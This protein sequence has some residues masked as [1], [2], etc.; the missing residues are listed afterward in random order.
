MNAQARTIVIDDPPETALTLPSLG[1][2]V[3]RAGGRTA[4]REVAWRARR[5]LAANSRA[6]AN[7]TLAACIHPRPTRSAIEN[8]PR[9]DRRKL[10]LAA[11]RLRGEERRWRRLYGSS[12]S[13]D[14]R[15][16]AVMLWSWERDQARLVERLRERRAELDRAAAR[17]AQEPLPSSAPVRLPPTLLGGG[18]A[19]HLSAL[20][21]PPRTVDR[22]FRSP[23]YQRMTGASTAMAAVEGIQKQLPPFDNL[24]TALGTSTLVR[25][26]NRGAPPG[27]ASVL[28][29]YT[30]RP[31]SPLDPSQT[32]QASIARSLEA[33]IAPSWR[34]AI[35]PSLSDQLAKVVP[36][37]EAVKVLQ[38]TLAGALGASAA[39]SIKANLAP[40]FEPSALRTALDASR[41]ATQLTTVLNRP[42]FDG[43]TRLL[44]QPG[45]LA[46]LVPSIRAPLDALTQLRD[47]LAPMRGLQESFA[48]VA[49]FMRSW[50]DDPLWFL[51]SVFGMGA[52][53]RFQGLT[54]EQVEEALLAALAEVVC[55]GEYVAALREVLRGAPYLN[56][57]QR[58]WLDHG[59]EHA[60]AGDWVQAVPPLMPGVEGALH[61]AAIGRALIVD[62]GGKLPA[63]EKLVKQMAVDKEY[64]AFVVRHVFGGIGNAF[65]HGRADSGERDQVLFAIVALAGWVD[66]FMNL[67]AM[68]VLAGQLSDRLDDAIERVAGDAAQLPV[69]G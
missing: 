68:R 39:A 37:L 16:F 30:S 49:E 1:R 3:V 52:A 13:L 67:S 9:H 55:D 63:A 14:E 57:N 66:F 2:V 20:L 32:F 44:A 64:T 41:V 27:F 42:L 7:A 38:G 47:V 26:T 31:F 35:H 29:P 69:A 65:R 4:H 5:P 15:F 21:G 61:H 53:R 23:A 33:A 50:E 12:L 11:L 6:F 8:L 25:G 51:L 18:I 17:R 10:M 48:D 28:R 36:G 34:T 24:A 59:L 56:D 40:A 58:A 22:F 43:R 54:R 45:G 62:R 19:K 60:A 46:A